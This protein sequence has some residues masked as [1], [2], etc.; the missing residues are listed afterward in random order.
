MNAEDIGIS[1]PLWKLVQMCWDGD[2]LR[3]P[4]MQ[5]VVEGVGGAAAHW[6]TDMPPTSSD[7]GAVFEKDSHSSSE[8]RGFTLFSMIY[9]LFSDPR[10]GIFHSSSSHDE[11]L[12]DRSTDSPGPG[13]TATLGTE[14]PLAETPKA[15]HERILYH[16]LLEDFCQPPPNSLPKKRKGLKYYLD[17]ISAS[18]YPDS[19]R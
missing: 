10:T 15:H 14:R 9:G 1:D 4:R 16:N 18:F 11:L 12:V 8:H 19:K 13:N 5:E 3:R 2:R 7:G 17:S 6:N